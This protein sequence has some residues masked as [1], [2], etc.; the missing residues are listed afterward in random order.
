MLKRIGILTALLATGAVAFGG[1]TSGAYCDA[2][3]KVMGL[4]VRI[5]ALEESPAA[6]GL[7]PAQVQQLN[8]ARDKKLKELKAELAAAETAMPMADH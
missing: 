6:V 1:P 5:A 2:H 7:K 4:K 8:E 3:C